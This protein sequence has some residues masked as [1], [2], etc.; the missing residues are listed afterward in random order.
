MERPIE[1]SAKKQA[2]V[3]L[4]KDDLETLAEAEN[5]LGLQISVNSKLEEDNNDLQKENQT[6]QMRLDNV[7]RDMSG[8][9][10]AGKI[11]DEKIQNLEERNRS[12]QEYIQ[13]LGQ[14]LDFR[15]KGYKKL[16]DIGERQ[17]RRKLNGLKSNVQ[18][19]LWFSKTFG[20]ELDCIKFKDELGGSHTIS[21]SKK[22][23]KS[24]KDL[25]EADQQKVKN[26]LFI[27]DKFCTGEE[28]YHEL[29]MAEGNDG[30]PRSYLIK[31]CK[32]DL[33]K[34]CHITAT[35]GPAPGAQL[36]FVEELKSVVQLQVCFL[37]ILY[38]CQNFSI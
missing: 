8:A 35:P 31:Q 33:N 25:G 5:S 22:V 2:R 23:R 11:A 28:A 24:Y 29:T 9:Q 1:F 21:Y 38:T 17:W 7:V 3:A 19:A 14:D 34:L 27:L 16:S 15:N 30:L 37:V 10:E 20:L 12:L 26:V 18:R 36:D 32:D 13:E 6:L 4:Q